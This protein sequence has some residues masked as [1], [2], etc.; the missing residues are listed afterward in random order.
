MSL[1]RTLRRILPLKGELTGRTP[2]LQA[3]PEPVDRLSGQ[4]TPEGGFSGVLSRMGKPL[5]VVANKLL[6][7]YRFLAASD[8]IV[9]RHEARADTAPAEEVAA[10][11]RIREDAAAPAKARPAKQARVNNQIRG[12]V[13]ARLVA[14]NRA[15]AVYVSSLFV[16]V[17]SKS[18]AAPGAVGRFRRVIPLSRVAKADRAPGEIAE[19][20]FN[21][22]PTAVT[23]TADRAPGATVPAFEGEQFAAVTARACQ[24][25]IAPTCVQALAGARLRSAASHASICAPCADAQPRSKYSA[26]MGLGN[27]AFVI[28]VVEGA[29]VYR[30]L[31]GLET[32]CRDPIVA[33]F[34]DEPF[35]EADAAYKYEFAGWSLEEGGEADPDILKNITG[36]R[37]VYAVFT[38]ISIIPSLED[39]TWEFIAQA[40][41]E[42]K[43]SEYW[44]IGD[45]KTVVTEKCT[46][47]VAIVAF[48]QDTTSEFDMA[49]W[50]YKTIGITFMTLNNYHTT[51]RYGPSSGYGQWDLSLIRSQVCNNNLLAELPADLQA[52]LKSVRHVCYYNGRVDAEVEDKVFIPSLSELGLG[53]PNEG[54]MYPYYADAENL[55][56]TYANGYW[57]RT[58]Y[59]AGYNSY[60]VTAAGAAANARY[61][62]YKA[63]RFGFCV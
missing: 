46:Y 2:K 15:A 19:S 40:S 28:F 10:E 61:S 38:A 17:T 48:D 39:A 53:G 4:M 59:Q 7:L 51:V 21:T 29:E 54:A 60:Y 5:G 11:S 49:A 42:G 57:T 52:V 14:Y 18:S 8:R 25:S 34:I 20:R 50:K 41:A 45:T 47:T 6:V 37:I 63:I 35:K 58:K 36:E 56:N 33:G 32:D 44:N 1:K 22:L 43:A 26:A 31:C 13:F 55:K 3:T 24:A 16:A 9:A 62:N 23:A 27:V 30:K 12:S